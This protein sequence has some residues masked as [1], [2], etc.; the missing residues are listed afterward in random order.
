MPQPPE[1]T[2]PDAAHNAVQ[3]FAARPER[4]LI[5]L[6]GSARHVDF[7]PRVAGLPPNQTRPPLRLALV[8]ERSGSMAGEKIET[9]RRAAIA[10]VE[11]L[12]ARDQLA[13][14]ELRR[15]D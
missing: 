13:G 9:A 11:R 3:E 10:V 15:P 1:S 2:D 8:L 7:V 4:R 6:A 14:G 12:E 5:R